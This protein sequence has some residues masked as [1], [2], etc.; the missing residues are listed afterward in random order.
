ML[1]V[2]LK[3]VLHT[4][5]GTLIDFSSSDVVGSKLHDKVSSET[6][7]FSLKMSSRHTFL[8]TPPLQKNKISI[9]PVFRE[10]ERAEKRYLMEGP[11]DFF[12]H[13]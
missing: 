13:S 12:F 10:D 9:I 4:E 2:G 6:F 11:K 1:D 5:T 8:Y 3:Q 7:L